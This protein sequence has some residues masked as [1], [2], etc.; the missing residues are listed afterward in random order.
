MDRLR[1]LGIF[2]AVSDAQS[3]TAGAKSLNVNASSATRAVN[4]LEEQLGVRLFTRTTRSVRLTDHGRAFAEDVR[5]ILA[6]LRAAEDSVTG[7]AEKP[8]G[9]L[10]VTCPQEFGRLYVA[11]LIAEFLDMYPDVRVDLLLIDRP[12]NLVEEGYDIALRI[13]DLPSS[14]LLAVR[15]GTVR[16]IIC[17][18]PDYFK[19]FGHPQAPSDLV[20]NHRVII[21]H[22]ASQ[23]WRFKRERHAVRSQPALTV[24]SVAASIEVARLGWGLCRVLSYQVDED[25]HAGTLAVT[26][27]EDEP[28]PLPVNLIH[29]QGRKPQTKLRSFLDFAVPR[30][31][32]LPALMPD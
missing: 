31:R 22:N 11:P 17:G 28:E 16:Q 3:F 23:Q 30:L 19:R 7:A 15:V 14:G 21:T 12:V 10:R 18:A 4:E 25:L 27:E 13:G 20:D 24:N 8:A 2:I 9:L 29:P 26:L 32:R 5:D 6:Q 1:A